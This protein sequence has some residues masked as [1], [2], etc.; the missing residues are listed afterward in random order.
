MVTACTKLKGGGVG[1]IRQ[2]VGTERLGSIVQSR[3]RHY[4]ERDSHA[5]L[6]RIILRFRRKKIWKEGG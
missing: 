4:G 6:K 3:G 1:D 2:L 5:R